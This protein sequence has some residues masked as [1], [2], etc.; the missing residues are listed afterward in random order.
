MK[1]DIFGQVK[2]VPISQ[3]G[4]FEWAETS[5]ATDQEVVRHPFLAIRIEDGSFLLLGETAVFENLKRFGVKH[6]PLQICPS[7]QVRL[8]VGRLEIVGFDFRDL[9]RLAAQH[10]EQMALESVG[11]E[12]PEGCVSALIEF[13]EREPLAIHM[14]HSTRLGCPVPLEFL[15]RSILT[16]G[17]YLPE[18][19]L[20]GSSDTPLKVVVPS[21]RLTIPRFS[22]DDL[23]NASLSERYFPPGIVRA[24]AGRRVLNVDFP[25]SVL[26]SDRSTAEIESFLRDL[27]IYREQ[28]CKTSFFE[29]QL[30]LL[31]R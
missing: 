16:K 22:L 3:I 5:A 18:V 8:A 28:T 10:P 14:R 23:I 1:D 13:P 29:G 24:S 27:I 4:T 31:N 6:L 7:G 30:Y 12:I 21:A 17:R 19:E 25:T 20:A 26:M 2:I 9:T 15:F 11:S